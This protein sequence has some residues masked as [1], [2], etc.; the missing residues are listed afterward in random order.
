MSGLAAA[1][2]WTLLIGLV[3]FQLLFNKG[4]ESLPGAHLLGYGPAITGL[5][6]PLEVGL[7]LLFALFATILTLFAFHDT[8]RP[9]GRR[10][11]A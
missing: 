5:L 11:G 1:V 10:I 7:D 3:V 8:R 9:S 6:L 2:A 4:V